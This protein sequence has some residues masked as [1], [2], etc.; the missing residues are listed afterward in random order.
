MIKS[1]NW[2]K[3]K[4]LV[5]FVNSNAVLK[6]VESHAVGVESRSAFELFEILFKLQ[7]NK[8]R[9]I[10]VDYSELNMQITLCKTNIKDKCL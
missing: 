5:D 7:L 3:T 1:N 2:I 10:V 8:M 4:K 9:L 6:C